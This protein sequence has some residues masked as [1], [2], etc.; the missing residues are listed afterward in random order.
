ML[1]SACITYYY[2]R[3]NIHNLL[4]E[5]NKY[6]TKD[7]EILIRNDNP[8]HKLELSDNYKNIKIFNETKKSIG[9]IESIKFLISKSK[10][11]Y[12]TIVSDDDLIS[13]KIFKHSKMHHKTKNDSLIFLSSV[14]KKYLN[15]KIDFHSIDRLNILS[16]FFQRKIYLSGTIATIYS[17]KFLKN[18]IN[19][20][21]LRKYNFDTLLFFI[22]LFE[23]KYKFFNLIYGFNDT[24]SSIISSGKIELNHYLVD[25]KI[26]IKYLK[27][28][29]NKK[30]L[31]DFT[32]F[33]VEN[34]YSLIFRNNTNYKI[35]HLILFNKTIFFENNEFF[36]FKIFLLLIKSFLLFVL[37][38][39]YNFFKY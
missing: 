8:N 35:K 22:S 29:S 3:N 7:L 30:M 34:F 2:R 37:R 39:V 31:Y 32:K 4:F 38:L 15:K 1:F 9:E 36:Y 18:K 6:K 17:R 28:H 24:K 27:K 11:E 21:K 20:I 16:S 26:L 23:S 13:H 10:G 33:S 25:F 5:L 14:N 19:K 12:I